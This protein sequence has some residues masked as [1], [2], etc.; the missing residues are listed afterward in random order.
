MPVFTI[1]SPDGRKIKIEAGDEGAAMRG[2][3]E[4]ARANPAEKPSFGGDY[5]NVLKRS[6]EKLRDDTADD[7]RTDWGRATTDN[8]FQQQAEGMGRAAR[9]AG[10]VFALAASPVT[11]LIEA[12]ATR[13]LARQV[14]KLPLRP[15]TPPR[16]TLEGGKARIEPGRALEGREA[17]DFLTGEFNAAAAA[18][19]AGPTRSP[20]PAPKPPSPRMRPADLK[21]AKD[22]AYQAVD[23]MG[24]KYKPT[25]FDGLVSV[26][27]TEIKAAK[28][29]PRLHP[30]AA[31]AMREIQKMRGQSPTLT[32]VD[33][34]RQFV[35]ENAI[36]GRSPG[37]QRIGQIMLRQIDDFINAAGPKQVVAGDPKAAAAKIKEA[38]DLNTRFRKVET[39]EEAMESAR[40]RAGSTGSGGNV[41]NAT[42]QNL[43]RVL[44]D[45]QWTPEEAKA[46]ESIVVGGH[47]QNFLRL[48]GKL[49]PTGNG[50]MTALNIGGAAANPVLAIPGVAGIVAKMGADAMTAAKVKKLLEL[51]AAG[52]TS[53]TRAPL[54]APS[55]PS[56]RPAVATGAALN[57]FAPQEAR[58]TSQSAR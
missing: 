8:V 27:D 16:F 58:R 34:L 44:E 10:N 11:G 32:E 55:I 24:V 45:G 23:S 40:L 36:A 9:M 30:G 12:G 39:V 21:P 1:Q 3:Q 5:G 38:R 47:G 50:L 57:L 7:Y 48:V 35:R 43:R 17:E 28:F 13:P 49:S 54:R 31:G 33:Q 51:I 52:G 14:N 15:H 6:W 25:T 2:A 56:P 18:V 20:A 19:R 53:P 22:A 26:M 41:D 29:N 37:E 4:W 42:R 46:L